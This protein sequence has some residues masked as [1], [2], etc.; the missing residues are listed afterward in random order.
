MRP[1]VHQEIEMAIRVEVAIRTKI[2]VEM[3]IFV[4][5]TGHRIKTIERTHVALLT[6]QSFQSQLPLKGSPA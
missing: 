4:M 2:L 5:I 6:E 1:A 3:E